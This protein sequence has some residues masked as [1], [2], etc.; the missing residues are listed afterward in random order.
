MR[1]GATEQ[2]VDCGGEERRKKKQVEWGY[3]T[4]ITYK[5]KSGSSTTH[6]W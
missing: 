5:K 1:E 6:L 2:T 3:I 4:Y